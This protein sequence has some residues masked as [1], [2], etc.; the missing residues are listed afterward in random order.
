MKQSQEARQRKTMPSNIHHH[1]QPPQKS[2]QIKQEDKFFSKLLSKESSRVNSSSRVLYYGGAPRAVPFQWESQPGTPIRDFASSDAGSS[3]PP[4]TPP[5]SYY[6]KL[7]SRRFMQSKNKDGHSKPKNVSS[8][9]NIFPKINP[10]TKKPHHVSQ[11][12]SGSSTSSSSAWSTT[13]FSSPSVASASSTESKLNRR[14]SSCARSSP[15]HFRLEDANNNDNEEEEEEEDEEDM[16]EL[17]VSKLRLGARRTFLLKLRSC[18]PVT[19]IKSTFLS[20]IGHGS[21]Q[22]GV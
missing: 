18:Y 9:S 15:V 17:P 3:F 22:G 8:K 6:S 11:S 21:G 2:L 10:N 12:S 7:K 14:D 16:F 5:P 13:S 19:N 20:I 1:E 4:L